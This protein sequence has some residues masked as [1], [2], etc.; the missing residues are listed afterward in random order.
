[1]AENKNEGRHRRPQPQLVTRELLRA[2]LA[3]LELRIVE[4]L[5]DRIT[6]LET[7]FDHKFEK[8]N[9][10]LWFAFSILAALIVGFGIF[11]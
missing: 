5:T 7:R 1:M 3:Q 4:R 6:G 10:R 11:G 8:L 9:G 2:E